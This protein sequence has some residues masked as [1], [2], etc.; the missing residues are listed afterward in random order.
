MKKVCTEITKK[1]GYIRDCGTPT[2]QKGFPQCGN[3]SVQLRSP[4]EAVHI[5]AKV[6]VC[7][8]KEASFCIGRGQV[9]YGVRGYVCKDNTCNPVRDISDVPSNKLIQNI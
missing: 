5:Y 6:L 8:S 7:N 9:P 1:I 3:A 4:N 2:F